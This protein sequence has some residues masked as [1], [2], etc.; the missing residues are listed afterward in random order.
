MG[1]FRRQKLKFSNPYKCWTWLSAGRPDRSTEAEVG[2]PVRSTDVHRRA[3]SLGQEV[4]RPLERFCSLKMAPVDRQR[5]LL[6]VFSIRSTGR[7][8]SGSTIINMT[9]ARSTTRSTGR[10]ILP[11]PVANGQICFGAIYIPFLEL[12]WRSFQ[13]EFLHLLSVFSKSFQVQKIYSLFCFEG[14]ENSRKEEVFGIGF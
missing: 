2:R 12:F 14:L 13:R 5:A 6:S 1:F 10:A 3:R 11:F 4:G 9:V 8:T 7:S